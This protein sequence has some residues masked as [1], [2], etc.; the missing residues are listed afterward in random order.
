MDAE[1]AQ[2]RRFRRGKSENARFC[3]LAGTHEAVSNNEVD[4]GPVSLLGSSGFPPRRSFGLR[5]GLFIGGGEEV[6]VEVFEVVISQFS[7]VSVLVLPSEAVDSKELELV[8]QLLFFGLPL[9]IKAGLVAA[10]L[11]SLYNV[12]ESTQHAPVNAL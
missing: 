3:V 2:S 5:S 1:F 12:E 4:L 7:A 6:R 9:I 11:D 8:L 10:V